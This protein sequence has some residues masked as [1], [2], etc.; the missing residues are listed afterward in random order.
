MKRKN[1]GTR[2]QVLNIVK[3]YKTSH[4]HSKKKFHYNSCFAGLENNQFKLQDEDK[5]V[6]RNNES[7]KK[8]LELVVYLIKLPEHF[9][10][11]FTVLLESLG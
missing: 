5:S 9:E 6:L 3:R 10:K 4:E 1:V 2:K 8:I 7:K 11:S